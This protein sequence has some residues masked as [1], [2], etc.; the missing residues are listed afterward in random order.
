M[1]TLDS[2]ILLNVIFINPK[3]VIDTI[4]AV[5]GF[6]SFFSLFCLISQLSNWIVWYLVLH[7]IHTSIWYPSTIFLDTFA[8]QGAWS[9]R[10]MYFLNPSWD[11]SREQPSLSIILQNYTGHPNGFVLMNDLYIPMFSTFILLYSRS[12]FF[13][14]NY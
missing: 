12:S 8:I 11:N 4:S 13:I 3:F 1:L 9:D 6:S 5:N 14:G 2:I 10:V 7:C